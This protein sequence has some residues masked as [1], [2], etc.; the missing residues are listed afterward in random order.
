MK[1]ETA[2]LPMGLNRHDRLVRLAAASPGLISFA[3]GLPDPALFP[4]RELG[5]AL[6]CA[7]FTHGESALQYGWPEGSEAL[8]ADVAKELLARGAKV[9]A[10]QI[11]ITS[12]AQQ[13]IS[14]AL[15]SIPRAATVAVDRETYPGALDIFR[16]AKAR[17]RELEQHCR[18]YYVM[19][20]VSNPRGHRMSSQ[21]RRELIER[22]VRA[23]GYIIED[24]AY[25]GTWFSGESARPLLADCRE[26]VFHVGTFSKT[27]CPGLR[28]GW[29]VAPPGLARR[30]LG[31]KQHQDLQTNGLAQALLVEYLRSGKFEALKRRARAR[32]RRKARL[33][34]ASV[35]QH[36]PE[37][38]CERPRGGF[39]LW[40]ESDL[41][42]DD[43]R[44]LSAAIELGASFD[45]ARVF[46]AFP[47]DRL[48]LRLC[49]SAV[50]E[51]D[52]DEGVARI[53][54]ALDRVRCASPR[55]P[56][57]AWAG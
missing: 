29:L 55:T 54:Q 37:F 5:E 40:L 34:W 9:P 8:R 41:V 11:V 51:A 46:R 42:V 28:V 15:S 56:L 3:G 20:S 4:R 35:Q 31:A 21:A 13:A 27:L 49:F 45:P 18:A 6:R 17:L 39:S 36:L 52:I 50:A 26:R 47:D 53:A 16:G 12:G 48:A 2:A 14:L 57:R 1:K 32:Y 25:D 24:D 38:R 33:L 30:A 43:E 23:R 44:L 22:A 7:L 19:P 10:E